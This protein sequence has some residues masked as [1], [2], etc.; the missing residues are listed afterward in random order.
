MDTLIKIST[1][2][3]FALTLLYLML[4]KDFVMPWLRRRKGWKSLEI[5][6]LHSKQLDTPSG[7]EWLVGGFVMTSNDREFLIE[8]FLRDV[9]RV[10]NE[11][12]T[13]IDSP[14][15]KANSVVIGYKLT[16]Y[17][18]CPQNQRHLIPRNGEE[19]GHHLWWE[20]AS[21]ESFEKWK[22]ILKDRKVNVSSDNYQDFLLGPPSSKQLKAEKKSFIKKWKNR[23]DGKSDEW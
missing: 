12:Q 9:Q 21:S 2:A 8:F 20:L 11:L 13:P 3:T 23:R 14:R 19:Y 1:I 17:P 18:E 22:A 16:H 5:H 15:V 7:Q 4:W 10:N 6:P